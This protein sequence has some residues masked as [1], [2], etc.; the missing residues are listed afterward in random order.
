M[1]TDTHLEYTRNIS[2]RINLG[3]LLAISSLDTTLSDQASPQTV[4]QGDWPA[5]SLSSSIPLL[6]HILRVWDSTC[7]SSDEFL[8]STSLPW[9][10]Q[11]LCGTSIAVF[12]RWSLA[13]GIGGHTPAVQDWARVEKKRGWDTSHFV[14]PYSGTELWCVW[15]L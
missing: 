11:H 14:P 4:G 13:A 2:S 8:F 9:A 1:L 6:S 12:N 3:Q 10:R 5:W 15:E 7:S